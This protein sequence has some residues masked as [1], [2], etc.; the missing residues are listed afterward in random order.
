MTVV[1]PAAD[2]Q[3]R[4]EALD[5]ARSFIVQ[6]PAG[7]GKTELLIQRFL[8]LLARVDRPEAVVAITFTRK[9]AAEMRHRIVAALGSA[10]GPRPATP[11]E[12]HTW[13]LAREAVTR[14]DRLDWR[15]AEHPARLRIQ[16]I[17]SLCAMLVRRMPWV[18]RMGAALRPV[19][20]AGHLYARAARRTVSMLDAEGTPADVT[21]AVAVLLAHLD[22]HFGRVEQL[23]SVMLGTRDQWMR[24]VV[25]RGHYG[26]L[27]ESPALG[28]PTTADDSATEGDAG[29]AGDAAVPRGPDSEGDAGAAGDDPAPREHEA[30][31][32]H[33]EASI[34]EVIESTLE[35]VRNG[36]PERYR[37]E[38]TALARFAASN[39]RASNRASVIDAC[40]EMT[41]FPGFDAESLPSWI[42]IVEMFLTG[43]G[44]RRRSL[45]VNQ[46]FPPS[47]A[48]RDAKERLARIDL[49]PGTTESLHELRTLPPPRFD[50]RQWDVLNALMLLLPV[51]VEQLRIVFREEGCVDFTEIGIGARAALG[52][53]EAPTDLA[54]S[55]DD[56]IMH[57][58]ID[59]FQDT[60]QSQYGLLTRLIRDWRP[61]D[62]RTLFLVGDPMQSIYGFREAEVGLFLQARKNGVGAVRPV[63]LALSVNFRSHP[64]VVEWVNRVLREAFPLSEDFLSGAVT[65]E[66]SKAFK[67]DD[68]DSCVRFHAFLDRD[69][70]AEAERV[71]EM[72]T[73]AR[74]RR[75]EETIAVLVHARSHLAGI[76]SALRRN[77]IR[78]RAVEIDALGDRP[79]VRD[80]LALTRA[81][82]HPGDRVA[83]LALLRAPWCGL[84]LT[85]LEALAGGDAP[86]AV[87]DLLQEPARRE[88]LSPDA[89]SRIDRMMP[90]LA[91]AFAL[92]AR[93]LVR[94]LVEGVWTALGGPAC[95]ETRT[96]REDAAAFLDLLERVQ[97]GLGIPDEKAFADDVARLF[98]PSDIEAA[99]DVQLLTI[100]RAK[101]LEFDTVIL[102]GLGRLPR[103]EDPRLLMW[104]EYARGRQSRLLLAPIR[105]TGGEKDPL[106]AYLARIESQ[107]R[108][109]ERTRLLY[110]AAT[111]ARKC[112]HLLGH[113]VPDPENES[114]KTPGSRTLLARIWHAVEPEFQEA[115]K[116]YEG[117][118]PEGET[119]AVK[120]RGVPLRRLVTGWTP[121][122]LPEDID[123]KPLYDPSDPDGQESGHPTFEWVTELQRR[124]GVVVHQMLQRMYAPDLLDFGEDR[125]RTA[126]RQEG[127]AGEKLDEA[128]SRALSALGNI[129]ADERGRWIL[130]RN[131][132][133]E[134][135]IALTTVLDGRAQ[136]YVV[137]RTFVFEGT[138][139]IID[140]KTSDHT[141]GDLEGFLDNEQQRYRSQLEGYAGVL[142][143]LESGPVNLGLY[144]PM[145]QGWRTWTYPG[146][147]R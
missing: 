66:P 103:S 19:D 117:K 89:R 98:A 65:Y 47:D 112:L 26:A 132:R 125:L 42:G 130:S 142:Q 88:R 79:V 9:A 27:R 4:L 95:L 55:L 22:N 24:H 115:L 91:E 67:A 104:H 15:L 74:A 87:W 71:V 12:A 90:V 54:R 116:D 50:E 21:G 58:L 52:P 131:P 16:T 106:Y 126:L 43:Q 29:T 2:Q 69:P 10:S 146:N 119:A 124:V 23:L 33:L 51:A 143:S 48:G 75:P 84:T 123:F 36:F 34:G 107:K 32:A 13:E 6:A 17:D 100:H 93:L 140:Y 35:R 77:G 25:H 82:L 120:P 136:R 8:A 49:D 14:N 41:G 102:P 81:L 105:A 73:E 11:H 44:T 97:D 99:G 39:L 63:P 38:T 113:A 127:L 111:R 61:D 40:H 86:S 45:N 46:G 7:S 72:I 101:G 1:D 85:D 138:R 28:G 70:E 145:L 53:D 94:R 134:R 139:W 137:D 80:L 5:T 64:P 57:L 109:N 30:L 135:E 76:V 141:G 144:F 60:S 92:R 114:L 133:D 147:P 129:V 59:E 78:F 110:V 56:R 31:R 3:Q 68:P 108:E 83:W 62:G 122:P 96:D 118:S 20:D 18:S 121:G 128:V 37:D